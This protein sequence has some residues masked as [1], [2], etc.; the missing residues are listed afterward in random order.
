MIIMKFIF[1]YKNEKNIIKSCF[2]NFNTFAY[3]NL[4][5][6]PNFVPCFSFYILIFSF[7]LATCLLSGYPGTPVSDADN[8]IILSPSGIRADM[9]SLIKMR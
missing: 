6:I 1:H 9:A 7:V 8:L 4:T 2:Y 3:I 5:F